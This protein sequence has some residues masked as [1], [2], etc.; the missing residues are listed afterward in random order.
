MLFSALFLNISAVFARF[1]SRVSPGAAGQEAHGHCTAQVPQTLQEQSITTYTFM[2]RG[3][4][5]PL[6]L[7]LQLSV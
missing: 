3:A 2:L 5:Q 6:V 7:Q 1:K 4:T